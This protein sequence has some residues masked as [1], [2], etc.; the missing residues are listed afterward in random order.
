MNHIQ[1]ISHGLRSERLAR[2][3]GFGDDR[4]MDGEDLRRLW[5]RLRRVRLRG[6]DRTDAGPR[7]VSDE[8]SLFRWASME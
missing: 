6:K 3:L 2:V 4:H 7:E 1:R 5:S 8:A